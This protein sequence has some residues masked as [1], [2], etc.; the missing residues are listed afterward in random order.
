MNKIRLIKLIGRM[1]YGFHDDACSI[2]KT[3]ASPELAPKY[4]TVRLFY[5]G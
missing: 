1:A 5:G 3:D 4:R 2:L